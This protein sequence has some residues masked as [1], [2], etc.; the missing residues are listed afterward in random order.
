MKKKSQK[1]GG[2][3]ESVKSVL[4]FERHP[5]FIEVGMLKKISKKRMGKIL[6]KRDLDKSKLIFQIITSFSILIIYFYSKF[7]L[8]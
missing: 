3:S 1:R 4:N 8:S 7:K 6:K 5:L 2:G